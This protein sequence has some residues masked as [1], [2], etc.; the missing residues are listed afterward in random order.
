LTP[1]ATDLIVSEYDTTV[2]DFTYGLTSVDAN[3]YRWAFIGPL[4][5][6]S[7][8]TSTQFV[9]LPETPGGSNA[10]VSASEG[11]IFSSRIVS[12]GS[13]YPPGTTTRPIIG[14]GVN[15]TA[16]VTVDASGE[17]SNVTVDNPGEG[18]SFGHIIF[19]AGSGSDGRIDFFAGP[20]NGYGSNP[21]RELPCW[22]V[23]L[24]VDISGSAEVDGDIPVIPF[25]QLS[26][27]REPD[28]TPSSNAADTFSTLSSFTV[29]STETNFLS[30][31]TGS[32]L[33]IGT[34]AKVWFD[35]SKL[36]GNFI[37]VFYHRNSSS[38]VNYVSFDDSDTVTHVNGVALNTSVA[39]DSVTP[40]GEYAQGSGEVVFI[41]NFKRKSRSVSQIEEIRIIIQL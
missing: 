17:I 15:A 7:S 2:G 37:R 1:F 25:H 18:Y 21:A 9:E 5:E 13:L 30:Y 3:G 35:T 20:A 36:E 26:V 38:R 16:T 27:L 28:I 8:F 19:S 29:A 31:A 40:E 22:F 11:Y 33:T 32:V 4:S 6:E 23:G 12:A 39:I 34:T 24:A 41:E 10:D 14:D